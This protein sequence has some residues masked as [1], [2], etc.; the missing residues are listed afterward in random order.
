MKIFMINYNDEL[1]S[2]VAECFL[3][4]G[5]EI[6]MFS[7]PEPINTK[8]FVF[9]SENNR[10]ALVN[11]LQSNVFDTIFSIEYLHEVSVL[12]NALGAIYLSWILYLP[13][14][15]IYRKSVSNLCNAIFAC[16]SYIVEMIKSSG[17]S[18]VFYLPNGTFSA[19]NTS[20]EKTG[21]FTDYG[22]KTVIQKKDV[23]KIEEDKT[24]YTMDSE[25]NL[26]DSMI[27]GVVDAAVYPVNFIGK[28]ATIPQ[29]S[30]F[31][32]ESLLSD[33]CRGYVDGLAHCQRLTYGKDIITDNIPTRIKEELLEKYPI[34]APNDIFV[35]LDE[36]ICNNIFRP[37]ITAQ[38]RM[39]LLS[40]INNRVRIFS[41]W[42]LS[43]EEKEYYFIHDNNIGL[44][45]KREIY[46][47]SK[48]SVYFAGRSMV[49]GIPHQCFDI[50]GAGS[51]LLTSYQNDILNHFTPDRDLLIFENEF[52]FQQKLLIYSNNDDARNEL[53][54]N[55]REK[56]RK[57]HLIIHRIQELLSVF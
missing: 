3:V 50:M 24:E 10:A 11:A 28:I 45:Q 30:V 39:I 20:Y 38:E 41:D 22:F 52:D 7:F 33:N 47:R 17:A 23:N 1:C 36:L 14:P 35:G 2:H 56:I 31:G 26:E 57:E 19:D 46:S 34:L 25:K 37:Y 27:E 8:E 44:S 21:E 54:I 5:Q 4:C 51:L 18:N 32:T 48:V 12:A 40:G 53:V 6:I 43:E 55:A 29:N 49:N 42:K 9:L 15:D 16:D 13:N